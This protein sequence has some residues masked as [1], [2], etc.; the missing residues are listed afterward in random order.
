MSE[1]DS[2][3]EPTVDSA[4]AAAE[5]DESNCPTPTA[6]ARLREAHKHWHD[7]LEGYQDPE[8]FRIALNACIQTLRNVTFALQKEKRLVP[9]F[10][11]WYSKHQGEMGDDFVMRWLLSARN[12]IVKQGDLETHSVATVRF[13]TDYFAA[14]AE[15]TDSLAGVERAAAP[16]V[17]DK[18]SKPPEE[19]GE[20]VAA[21][22][23][24]LALGEMIEEFFNNKQIPRAVRADSSVSIER[25]WRA[26]DLPAQE[27]LDVL[28]HGYGVLSRILDDAHRRVGGVSGA[29]ISVGGTDRLLPENELHAGR[30]P[31]MVTSR[32][33]RTVTFG[34]DGNAAGGL[35]FDFEGFDP[36]TAEKAFKRYNPR[37]VVM[38]ELP[39]NAVDALPIYVAQALSILKSGEEHGWFIFYFRG[40]TMVHAQT[41]YAR[42]RSDKRNLAK[43]VAEFVAVYTIDGVI[44]VGEAWTV[45]F[46][47][48]DEGV[49]INPSQSKDRTE[50]LIIHA[51]IAS[52]TSRMA[53]IPF[54][55]RRFGR[56]VIEEPQFD[57][58]S[59]Y[60]FL[61]P[62]RAVW[63]LMGLRQSERA[64]EP[65]EAAEPTGTGVEQDK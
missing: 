39:M 27:L 4:H 1:P 22:S 12:R 5:E 28:A 64:P 24:F 16:E 35:T 19:D 50:A 63:R 33:A 30:L 23:P 14:A 45:S 47:T 55:R 31:C 20:A 36:K 11:N 3:A 37:R 7:A 8:S 41:L 61:E 34:A 13:T 65:P 17:A 6:H 49:P 26:D 56:P 59:E 48:D 54:R 32:A 2:P 25:S 42:D 53:V 44:V 21:S 62:V 52:G 57:H 10:D 15:V 40:R 51:E 18:S 38:Q 46:E 43:E 60:H 29:A 9:D 58:A